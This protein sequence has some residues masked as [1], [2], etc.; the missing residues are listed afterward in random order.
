MPKFPG[1]PKCEL[2]PRL[3]QEGHQAF[4][5]GP[6]SKNLNG[7]IRWQ[8]VR[9]VEIRPAELTNTICGQPQKIAPM[10]LRFFG[11]RAKDIFKIIR[12]TARCHRN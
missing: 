6:A 9:L 4:L 5:S 2:A 7:Y 1:H 12:R 3:L 8:E 10:F 11:L